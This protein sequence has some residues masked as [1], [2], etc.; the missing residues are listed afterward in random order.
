M[1]ELDNAKKSLD[2]VLADN[3]QLKK[4][5]SDLQSAAST[6]SRAGAAA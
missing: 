1:S 5:V 2:G 3:E 6:V 4:A